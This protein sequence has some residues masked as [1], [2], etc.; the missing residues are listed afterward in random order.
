MPKVES[1]ENDQYVVRKPK[2]PSNRLPIVLTALSATLATLLVPNHIATA[3]AIPVITVIA[4][5]GTDGPLI[6][7]IPAT[8]AQLWG[9]SDVTLVKT[10]VG[11][12]LP[13]FTDTNHHQVRWID[14]SGIIHAG[15]GTGTQDCAAGLFQP[16]GIVSDG[17]GGY[18]VSSTQCQLVKHVMTDGSAIQVAGRDFNDP[19]FCAPLSDGML[20]QD[21]CLSQPTGLGYNLATSDLYI[22]DQGSHRVLRINAGH[23]FIMA[24]T[25]TNGYSGD[26]GP[27]NNAQLNAPRAVAIVNGKLYIADSSNARIRAVDL[28]SG[29]IGTVA[30]NGVFAD[31]GDGGPATVAGLS[32]PQGLAL[33]AA[34]NLFESGTGGLVRKIDPNG[35]ISTYATFPGSLGGLAYSTNGDLYTVGTSGTTQQ[36]FRINLVTPPPLP[37]PKPKSYVSLGDSVASGEGINYDWRWNGKNWVRFGPKKPAWEPVNDLS[38]A[39]Q[40]CHR[41]LKAYPYLVANRL[42]YV[43]HNFACTGASSENGILADQLFKNATV[44]AQLGTADSSQAPPSVSFAAANPDVVSISL[45]PDDVQFDKYL[46]KCY[47]SKNCNTK[48]NTKSLAALLDL[49][50]ANLR[51]VIQ[52]LDQR[53]M[54]AGKKM[55][56]VVT[57]VYNPFPTD[58]TTCIDTNEGAGLGVTPAEMAWITSGATPAQ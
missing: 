34:G 12:E 31:S 51:N 23:V 9:P 41:S 15:Y 22:A 10:P 35:V 38:T 17:A 5:T 1:T 7:D 56:V 2:R 8:Q 32:A 13:Y 43:L 55:R 30:G 40:D 47:K 50:K 44:P 37:T 14:Y 27:A 46:K 45:G 48:A 54:V 21:A 25:G 58:G 11:D 19:R 20:I 6:N 52:E 29:I 28:S 42:S 26:G 18:F 24:G 57:T 36:V 53:A 16:R 33:D 49:Q 4:G 39:N 3:A